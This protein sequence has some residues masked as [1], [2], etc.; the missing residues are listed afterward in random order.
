MPP[1]SEAQRANAATLCDLFEELG[2]EAPTLCEGWATAR[3]GRPS[4]GARTTAGQWARPGLGSPGRLHRSGPAE[5]PTTRTPWPELVGHGTP[6]PPALLRPFDRAMNTVEFFI[7]VEDV[8]RA[9]PGWEPR[10][11]APSLAD[12]LWKPGGA[13]WDGQAGERHRRA[14]LRRSRPE[15]GRGRAGGGARRRSGR[16]DPVRGGAPRGQPGGDHRRRPTG[17]PA[18]RG[19]SAS[20]PAR[21]PQRSPGA[22]RSVALGGSSAR[23]GTGGRRHQLDGDAVGVDQLQR[24]ASVLQH[25]AVVGQPDGREWSAHAARVSPSG[26]AKAR[27]S[28]ARG[29]TAPPCSP[30]VST[31]TTLLGGGGGRRSPPRGPRRI[32]SRPSAARYQ[33]PTAATSRDQQLDVGEPGERGPGERPAGHVGRPVGGAARHAGRGPQSSST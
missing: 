28:R 8:R 18:P 4:G 22:P 21:L 11:L 27:W 24:R 26:T 12:A 1:E 17:R 5:S 25:H 2:P 10:P 31:M 20:S 14:P 33:P 6:G 7:H 16:A 13:R 23:R 15:G 9:Q 30:T 3:P 29:P 32:P 19:R